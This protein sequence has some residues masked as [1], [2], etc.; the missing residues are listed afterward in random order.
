MPIGLRET[1]VVIYDRGHGL[2][3]ISFTSRPPARTY[4]YPIVYSMRQVFGYVL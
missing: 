1:G 3:F 4:I 2:G